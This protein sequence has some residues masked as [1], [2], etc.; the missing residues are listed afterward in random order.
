LAERR[1]GDW[2]V[3]CEEGLSVG[4]ALQISILEKDTLMAK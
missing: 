1:E 3:V 2:I 4:E